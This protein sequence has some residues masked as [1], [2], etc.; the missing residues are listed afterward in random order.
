MSTGTY[1]EET[2]SSGYC[3]DGMSQI[4]AHT[5]TSALTQTPQGV[6][7]LSRKSYCCIRTDIIHTMKILIGKKRRK[8]TEAYRQTGSELTVT[9][10]DAWILRG[11]YAPCYSDDR[12]SIT[13]AYLACLSVSRRQVIA[14]RQIE[15]WWCRLKWP[16]Q[17][18]KLFKQWQSVEHNNRENNG[19]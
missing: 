15:M 16:P 13:N 7:C 12:T 8:E 17:R 9:N 6:K 5:P 11:I 2:R 1:G 10:R 4:Q 19:G 14:A 3:M 18:R